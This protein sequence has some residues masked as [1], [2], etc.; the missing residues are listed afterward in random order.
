MSPQQ[1]DMLLQRHVQTEDNLEKDVRYIDLN[2]RVRVSDGPVMSGHNRVE[3][4]MHGL[5]QGFESGQ[6]LREYLQGLGHDHL[7][8]L[9]V[10]TSPQVR[11]VKTLACALVGMGADFTGDVQW[12]EAA[13]LEERDAGP[14]C[15]GKLRE[16]R[17]QAIAGLERVFSEA[18]YRYP[19]GESASD[20]G[21][22]AGE[23]LIDALAREQ[24]PLWAVS[25]EITI[26]GA[27]CRLVHGVVDDRLWAWKGEVGNGEFFHLRVD[28]ASGRGELVATTS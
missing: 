17:L 23:F 22:R 26:M 5:R 10:V 27:L 25:H 21:L 7:D 19:G 20:C 2:G 12:D 18:H 6:R 13:A 9:Y 14:L 4:T 15:T 8:K 28:V 16:E 24:R 1:I 11:A 3:P